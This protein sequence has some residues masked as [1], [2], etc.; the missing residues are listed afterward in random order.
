MSMLVS[1]LLL[2]LVASLSESGMAEV[3]NEPPSDI[4]LGRSMHRCF[5]VLT[6]A[7]QSD[8][9]LTSLHVQATSL[10]LIFTTTARYESHKQTMQRPYLRRPRGASGVKRAGSTWS[11]QRHLAYSLCQCV[12]C[13]GHSPALSQ[14]FRLRRTMNNSDIPP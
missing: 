8:I 14:L 5:L 13:R 4:R 9:H 10:A 11:R 12:F 1:P 2:K 3:T 7:L 6:S